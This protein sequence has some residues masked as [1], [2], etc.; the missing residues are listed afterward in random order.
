M[1]KSKVLLQISQVIAKYTDFA[2]QKDPKK[3]NSLF[4]RNARFA[5]YGGTDRQLLFEAKNAK[6]RFEVFKIFFRG[7]LGYRTRHFQT[8]TVLLSVKKNR[9]KTRTLVLVTWTRYEGGRPIL[10]RTG[11]Y[12]DVFV[13]RRR[14]WK[15]RSRRVYFDSNE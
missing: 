14:G 5:A 9:V 3:L 6:G 11:H 7:S 1:K 13:K 15:F 12:D 2:D 10:K 4:A 8:T